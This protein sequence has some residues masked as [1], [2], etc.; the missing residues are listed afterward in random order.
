MPSN[1]KLAFRCGEIAVS[2]IDCD[3]LFAFLGAK[4][5]RFCHVDNTTWGVKRL[6]YRYTGSKEHTIHLV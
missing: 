4:V 1:D 6:L 5:L 3:A 2:H